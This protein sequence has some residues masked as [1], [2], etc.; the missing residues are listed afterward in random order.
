MNTPNP[1]AVE[2]DLHTLLRKSGSSAFLGHCGSSSF[3]GRCGSPAFLGT[4]N[5]AEEVTGRE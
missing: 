5:K 1:P 4:A 3:L 2:P